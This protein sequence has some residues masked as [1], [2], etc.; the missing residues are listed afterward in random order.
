[1]HARAIAF[2]ADP[3]TFAMIHADHRQRVSFRGAI[4]L[5]YSAA[6]YAPIARCPSRSSG[7]CQ[8]FFGTTF[9]FAVVERGMDHMRAGQRN[10]QISKPRAVHMA[11]P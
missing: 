8:R 1:M 3:G 11:L 2:N 10:I 6:E 7:L 4:S 9:R 5:S